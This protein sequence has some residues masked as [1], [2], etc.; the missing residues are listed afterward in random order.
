MRFLGQIEDQVD[1]RLSLDEI[2]LLRN[3]LHELCEEMQ[4]SDND[5]QTILGAQRGEADALLRRIDAL[6]DRLQLNP[7][8][9]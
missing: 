6:V 2:V 9:D 3:A 5:F 4:F 8:V 1:V 7:D